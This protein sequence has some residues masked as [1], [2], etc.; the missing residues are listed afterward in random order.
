MARSHA[1]RSNG[2]DVIM[3]GGALAD[4]N[5]DVW[6][7]IVQAG[8][9]SKAKF[10]VLTAASIPASQDPNAGN[11]KCDNSACNGD[12]YSKLLLQYGA[13]S[14]AW[15]PVDLDHKAAAENA[16]LASLVRGYTGFFIGGGDQSRYIECLVQS[17]GRTDSAVL[18]AVRAAVA[19]GAG[20]A[21]TSA[22]TAILQSGP[23]VSG[24]ESYYGIRDG[25]SAGTSQ[26]AN[27]VTYA[28]GGGWGFFSA[29]LLDTHFGVRGRHGRLIRLL[30]DTGRKLGFGIDE[31]TAL[32]FSGGDA[33]TVMGT[34]NVNVLDLGQA[35]LE[36]GSNWGISGVSWS[37]LSAGDS[38]SL[39]SGQISPARSAARGLESESVASVSARSS[40]LDSTDIFS[41][42]DNQASSGGRRNPYE[43][44]RVAR[45]VIKAGYRYSLSETYETSPAFRVR[46]T[47]GTGFQSW[48]H[49]S[50]TSFKYMNVEIY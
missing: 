33:L 41:S 28:P 49:G 32:V 20:I 5:S 38:M 18:A 19:G 46:L 43:M 14:A 23:M 24:G 21:G 9:G 27:A 50:S 39:S 6:T 44:A 31:D 10:G 29:A 35:A 25:T 45:S 8:G 30:S 22:G 36:S 17:N 7:R 37:L 3:V 15:I 40:S 11:S 2:G 16:T 34:N 26:D 4:T 12:Y 42:P 47:K 48:Q 1:R 13:A